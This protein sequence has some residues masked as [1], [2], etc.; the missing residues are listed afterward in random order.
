MN[1]IVLFLPNKP[2]ILQ[3]I[4]P[5][6]YQVLVEFKQTEGTVSCSRVVAPVVVLPC[7]TRT[8]NGQGQSV[9]LVEEQKAQELEVS[10]G[11]VR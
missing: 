9:H 11:V 1:T 8:Q 4:F 10:A 7:I 5:A 3:N 2:P 6:G